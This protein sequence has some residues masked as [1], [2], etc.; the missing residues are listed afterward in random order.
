MKTV[1]DHIRSN[2]R[3][4]WLLVAAFPVVFLAI[5]FLFVWLAIFLT[6]APN[7]DVIAG[8]LSVT[9]S[10]AIP[11]IALCLIWLLI[12]WAF[13]D[14]M[15]LSAANAFQI[16]DDEK[17]YRDLFR[18]VENTALAAG[19]PTP[20]VYIIDDPAMNAFATGRT[21]ADAS[22]AFTTGLLARLSNEEIEGVIAH[23]MAH[24]GNRDIRLDMMLITGLGVTIFAADIIFRMMLFSGNSGGNNKSRGQ[25]MAILFAVWMAFAVFNFLVAP[26]MRMAVSRQREY[27]AD[28]TGAHITRNPKALA[29]ALLKIS[30]NPQIKTKNKSMEAAFIAAPVQSLFATH[31]P[32]EK[33]VEKLS[34]M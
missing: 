21:P 32:I 24:V 33:R 4:T 14:S 30:G 20:K 17:K 15:I 11:V 13:G 8:T 10:V 3:K 5:V 23:E 31:P 1:Y 12:S 34:Q 7:Q 18:S 9:T 22:V 28:A 19:L 16:H 6:A 27:L 29:S 25:M 2:N 26:V